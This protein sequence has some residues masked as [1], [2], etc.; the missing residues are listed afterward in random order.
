MVVLGQRLERVARHS[1]AHRAG[2][3]QRLLLTLLLL[4]LVTRHIL[5]RLLRQLWVDLA[6]LADAKE[7]LVRAHGGLA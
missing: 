7:L 1:H 3:G 5:Q 4:E 6:V 2:C